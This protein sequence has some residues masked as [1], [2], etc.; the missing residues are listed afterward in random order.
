M[1]TGFAYKWSNVNGLKR[2]E[3]FLQ[4]QI[5][6]RFTTVDY[7]F[8]MDRLSINCF[9]ALIFLQGALLVNGKQNSNSSLNS[10]NNWQVS[11]ECDQVASTTRRSGQTAQ[12]KVRVPKNLIR[13]EMDVAFSS[14]VT[15][16]KVSPISA[17]IIHLWV[18]S[19][20]LFK[21]L[22]LWPQ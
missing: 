1:E 8:A 6:N 12:F 19:D 17:T 20:V 16:L 5:L 14:P 10:V 11:G 18:L 21:A 9:V 13:W 3:Y 22:S 4:I 7:S 2:M 15:S